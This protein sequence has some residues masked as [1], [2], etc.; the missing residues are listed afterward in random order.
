M[1]DAKEDADLRIKKHNQALGLSR[2]LRLVLGLMRIAGY[3]F[4]GA[5]MVARVVSGRRPWRIRRILVARNAWLGDLVVFLP[6][7]AA[8]RARFPGAHVTLGVQRGFNAGGIL[9][10]SGLVDE[11]REISFPE[12]GWRRLAGA[13]RLFAS[14][15]DLAIHGMYYFMLRAAFFSGAPRAAGT[16]DG[17]PL[18][19]LLDIAVPLQALRHEADNNLA[20]AEALGAALPPGERVPRLARIDDP[21][22]VARLLARLSLPARAPLVALHPGSKLWS[23]RWPAERFAELAARLLEERPA[24][25]VV[26]TGTAGEAAL[27][28]SIRS[29]VP[30]PARERVVDATGACDLSELRLLLGACE[31]L[32]CNDTG[33]M[34]VARALG[35]PL[36]ALLGPEND[37]RWGPHPLGPGPAI[38]LRHQ[39]PCAPCSRHMC[40]PHWCLRLLTVTEVHAATRDVSK[41]AANGGAGGMLVPLER[42]QQQHGWADVAAAGFQLPLVSVV[43]VIG[44]TRETEQAW[45]ARAF[46]T[47]AAQR[48]PRIEVVMV[49]SNGRP[50]APP[51]PLDTGQRA[52]ERTVTLRR[53]H[54][55]YAMWQAILQ[56][57]HGE[58]V[59]LIEVGDH[60]HGQGDELA[61]DVAAL[62]RTPAAGLTNPS[63]LDD[64]WLAGAPARPARCT[65]R[66]TALASALD[67]QKHASLARPASQQPLGG[68]QAG[69]GGQ[70][71]TGG[72][73]VAT[74]EDCAFTTLDAALRTLLSSLPATVSAGFVALPPVRSGVPS[75]A[76]QQ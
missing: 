15:Y 17:H 28:A 54:D 46:D 14:G 69:G 39:V 36:V 23:R 27:A 42:R 67:D 4:W 34:H 71:R 68:D 31:A 5:R 41:N 37:L 6:T 19:A 61:D 1:L 35:T 2:P 65:F 75:M 26:L 9:E 66:R 70:A 45:L 18:Q 76:V 62:V 11:V 49:A 56:E 20:V 60:Q 32:V 52:F 24:L 55:P 10:S 53:Q 50:S 29:L 73:P 47:A 25:N 58:F 57:A 33:V 21:P 22:R 43:L 16:D 59:C 72:V 48:Y 64:G 40:E 38:A 3:A 13:L 30:E 12:G 8:L 7:L 44:T 63:P 51:A 74:G